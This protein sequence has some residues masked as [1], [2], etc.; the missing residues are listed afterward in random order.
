MT[1]GPHGH[2]DTGTK[3]VTEHRAAN[4]QTRLVF[5]LNSKWTNTE[6]GSVQI[7]GRGHISSPFLARVHSILK[8]PDTRMRYRVGAGGGDSRH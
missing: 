8:E 2:Q 7:A 3:N 4:H 1:R 6:F 5:I